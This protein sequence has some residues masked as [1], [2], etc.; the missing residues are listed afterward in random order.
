[1][2]DPPPPSPVDPVME[3]ANALAGVPLVAFPDQDHQTHIEVHLTF[4]DNDFVKSNPVAVQGLVSHILQHVS[5]MAQN[6]AQEMAMQDPAMMQQL[7]QEQMMMDQGQPVPPNPAMANYVATA[8]L[9]A[10]QEIMP[11]LEEILEVED[12]VVELKNKELDIREQENEDDKEIAERKLELE[13]EKIKSQED[14]AALRAGVD[15]DR[16]R[17]G[18]KS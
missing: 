17:R 9:G 6:E 10:L 5:L 12:G 3:N 18:G 7:Q 15:R 2:P 16:N 1:M 8:E 4:L 14:I 11:R 13:E